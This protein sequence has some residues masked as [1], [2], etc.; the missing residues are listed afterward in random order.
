MHSGQHT[1]SQFLAF[2]AHGDLVVRAD[3]PYV[4]QVVKIYGSS[5]AVPPLPDFQ[6]DPAELWNAGTSIVLFDK[7][8]DSDDEEV[9]A[10]EAAQGLGELLWGNLHTHD[11]KVYLELLNGLQMPS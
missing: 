10:I 5:D 4:R 9:H 2:A 3:R 1:A 7:N 8:I 6:F 11:M